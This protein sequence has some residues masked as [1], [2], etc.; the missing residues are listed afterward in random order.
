MDRF[1]ISH[2]DRGCIL[3][4]QCA[5]QPDDVQLTSMAWI[6]SGEAGPT[7]LAN[8]TISPS[9][10]EVGYLVHISCFITV[11]RLLK[12]ARIRQNLQW[13][14][15]SNRFLWPVPTELALRRDREFAGRSLSAFLETKHNIYSGIL[16]HVQKLPAELR[17]QIGELS[18]PS[19][20]IG[21]CM[22]L[23]NVE[24][25]AERSRDPTVDASIFKI[26]HVAERKRPLVICYNHISC[27]AI[28]YP[29]ITQ[30]KAVAWYRFIPPEKQKQLAIYH[31]VW[32]MYTYVSHA[33][34]G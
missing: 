17:I 2:N 22:L 23:R 25:M 1:R 16:S 28:G 29:E 30:Q 8:C 31:K 20:A 26:K 32:T 14:Y 34:N 27:T 33:D 7:R 4:R 24:Y 15:E 5:Y 19:T 9:A 10:K 12:Q 3:C 18:H 13:L 6:L 21:M 11:R